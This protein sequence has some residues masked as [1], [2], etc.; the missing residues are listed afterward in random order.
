MASMQRM[1]ANVMGGIS[2]VKCY[3]STVGLY[4]ELIRHPI[5]GVTPIGL[6]QSY[7]F[8]L[9]CPKECVVNVLSV[10]FPMDAYGCIETAPYNNDNKRVFD[11][12]YD[13]V[14]RFENIEELRAE[15]QRLLANDPASIPQEPIQE[16]DEEDDEDRDEDNDQ[17]FE[18]GIENIQ[19]S[20]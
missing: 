14:C 20:R 1:E 16:E 13:D 11:F 18:R 6:P 10:S 9:R 7:A 4:D 15:I 19:L 8:R 2:P 17:E 12:G 3:L 5:E